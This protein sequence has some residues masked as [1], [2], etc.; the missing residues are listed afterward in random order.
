MC[1][2]V[3]A[4]D[5]AGPFRLNPI[6]PMAGG[7]GTGKAWKVV[8]NSVRMRFNVRFQSQGDP[9]GTTQHQKKAK[10]QGRNS[11]VGDETMWLGMGHTSNLPDIRHVL[12][13][14]LW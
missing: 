11:R 8:K 12:D 4:G 14:I 10:A 5:G 1:V 7:G 3:P 2:I 13:P 6:H 9:I